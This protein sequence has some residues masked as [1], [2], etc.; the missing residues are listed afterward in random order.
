MR[1]SVCP[2][3]AII[4]AASL[5][6]LPGFGGQP[7]KPQPGER[8]ARPVL[9]LVNATLYTGVNDS[10]IADGTLVI[11]DGKVEYAGPDKGRN[12][13]IPAHST[14]RNLQGAVVIPGLVDTHSHVGLFSRPGVPASSDGNEGSGP[15]QPGVRAIDSFHP[16]DP[17]VRMALAGGVTTANVMPGS[18]N[19]IG[20]QT[21]YV[22]Y[23][24]RT[25]EEMRVTGQLPDGTVVVGG[26][27]MANGENP[28]GYGRTKQQAP[29]TRMKVAALQREQFVKAKEYKAKLDAGTKV[30]RDT[31]LEPLVEVLERKRTV[32]FHC[33]RAD[34]LM[35]AVRIAEEF[36]FEIVLQ[37]ATEGY[38][39]A[40]I[41]AKKRIP[42]SLTL[43]DS[44][45]GKAETIGLLE[46][47]AAIL[48][49][50]GV[51]VAINT[52]DGIT[53]SRFFLRT[54][55]IAVRGGMA[56]TT[57][58]KALTI[59]PAKLMHLDHRVGSLEKGKDADFVVLS[60]PPFSAY[61]QVLETYIEGRKLFDRADKKDWSY[62]A[63]GFALANPGDLPAAWKPAK[64]PAGVTMPPA[65]PETR[66]ARVPG[67]LY[68]RAGRIHTAAGGPIR[69]GAVVVKDGVIQD[70]GP[71]NTLPRPRGGT[72]VYAAE[73]TPGLID[74]FCVAG[75]SGAWNIPADQDQ[76][77]LSD[78]NQ[79]DLRV[80]DG[81]N[82]TEGLIEFVR[83]NGVTVV[84]ATPG[85]VNPIAG[86]TGIF[87]TD[88]RTAETAAI[89]PV[90]AVLVN[91]GE[92]S[93]G[94]KGP[95][96]R[97]GVA[98][99][100]RKAF[101]DAQ[102]NA[103]KKDAPKNAKHAA[104]AAALDGTVPVY[105]AAHRASDITTAL[106]IAAEFKLKPVV[107]LG[108]EAY[109]TA[110]EL[111]AAGVPVV[112]HPTM[113]RAGSSLETLHAFTG[114]AAVLADKGVPLAVST[115]FEGY[116]PK[117][118]VLRHEA[119]VAAANGLG[120][121][122]ALKAVTIDAAKLLG[123]A[124]KYGSIEK[125]KVADL[126]LYDGDPFETATHV[127]HTIMAGRVVY[128]RSEYLKLPFERRVLPVLGGGA[129]A[130]CC[131][132]VW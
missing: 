126:V 99:L 29:F 98:G 61:T 70:L 102:A 107:A 79:A 27:K 112:V 132:G 75:L 10:P 34:D 92:A 48:T 65:E 64:G 45:G 22:K 52:D 30:D 118:R 123:I 5:P 28:K 115:A 96:T 54:G 81:F 104:L 127:T 94:G 36:G 47:N 37:H 26:L 130:G 39:V 62:Q 83:A 20:G 46:E 101:A 116:V 35:T 42:V 108:T 109:R 122:R 111:K 16:D 41:L 106:R 32:H 80:L 95:T 124:E 84:H 55:A 85:R 49:K 117:T 121:D 21:L 105:F 63:G 129:G 74:A 72:T 125:G 110:D 90:A 88:G 12:E 128:D 11:R 76:D 103:A 44:P 100:V 82:P 59:I 24:G 31:A 1:R 38:R 40:E 119:S 91:L 71:A 4:A 51:G 131:L 19:V 6:L 86:Q 120:H 66:E 113:Q 14:I 43:I 53:E 78:P 33:H 97:M 68:V 58:L 73:V 69:D 15:V 93:K 89:K 60:G 87:R 3:V 67:L 25:A 50:A 7:E 13:P 114:S 17:G 77:E 9:V 8:G 23:R 56:E 18:G 57:A 2:A